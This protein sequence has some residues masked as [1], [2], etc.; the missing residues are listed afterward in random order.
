M[1]HIDYQHIANDE[2]HLGNRIKGVKGFL[3]RLLEG[4]KPDALKNVLAQKLFLVDVRT[5]E[6][7]SAGSVTGAVNIPLDSIP[8]NPSKFKDKKHI[9]VFCSYG[10]V[11]CPPIQLDT[12]CC[13]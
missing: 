12:S 11:K 1:Q 8:A 13:K 3:S 5:P 4:L 2:C 9:V 10:T 6:A 7:F